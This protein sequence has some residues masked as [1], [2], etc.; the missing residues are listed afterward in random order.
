M[1]ASSLED[2]SLG[3]WVPILLRR[4][5]LLLA[6][7]LSLGGV[8]G[9]R[10]VA[11]TEFTGSHGSYIFV[12]NY[13]DENDGVALLEGLAGEIGCAKFLIERPSILGGPIH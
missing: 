3:A 9:N 1:Y 11:S 13:V 7:S 5:G 6:G 8:L 12:G 10:G 2:M 4:M